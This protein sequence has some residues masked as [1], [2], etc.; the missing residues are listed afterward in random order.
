MSRICDICGKGLQSGNIITRHGMPKAKGG[1]GL[2]TTGITRRRFLPN[3]QK[4]RIRENGGV[5]IRKVC[6]TCIKSGKISKA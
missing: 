5:V 2:H 1:I 6:T 4:I 3:L